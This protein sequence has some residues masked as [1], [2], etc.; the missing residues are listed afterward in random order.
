MKKKLKIICIFAAV[1]F[2]LQTGVLLILNN[3]VFEGFS[4]DNITTVNNTANASQAE[5]DEAKAEE[6]N[7]K[8]D[9]NSDAKEIS[10][11]RSNKYIAYIENDKINYVDVEDNIKKTIDDL[12]PQEYKW[13]SDDNIVITAQNKEYRNRVDIYLYDISTNNL[14]NIQQ[15]K[16]DSSDCKVEE[17]IC[18]PF[19]NIM[20]VKVNEYN[21]DKLY[22]VNIKNE[23]E[24]VDTVVKSINTMA[25]I[26]HE[27]KIIY[28]SDALPKFYITYCDKKLKFDTENEMVLLGV[29]EQDKI[30]IAEKSNDEIIN[31]YSGIMNDEVSEWNKVALS[32]KMSVENILVA[33]DGAY[34][35]DKEKSVILNLDT[36]KEVKYSGKVIAI[37]KDKAFIINKNQIESINL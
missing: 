3:K 29:D 6:N 18:S 13:T 36:N 9:I 24:T 37:N 5:K 19:K 1:S 8:V 30:F 14:K 23:I 11:S 35:V 26:P 33:N 15:I 21:E 25:I 28:K 16:L 31:I 12:V 17:V 10:V 7:I 32:K 20:F 4:D 34:Y 2:A 27:D 22:K